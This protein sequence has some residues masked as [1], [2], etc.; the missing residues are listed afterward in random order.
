MNIENI[1]TLIR[2]GFEPARYFKRSAWVKVERVMEFLVNRGEVAR[3]NGEI[4]YIPVD[5]VASEEEIERWARM[6]ITSPLGEH[7]EG[8]RK[9]SKELGLPLNSGELLQAYMDFNTK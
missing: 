4:K 1:K 7:I 2:L 8:M 9:L 5:K 6:F 3:L